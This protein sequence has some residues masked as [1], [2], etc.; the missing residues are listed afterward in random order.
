[1]VINIQ[2]RVTDFKTTSSLILAQEKKKDNYF[3][4]FTSRNNKN[5]LDFNNNLSSFSIK[6]YICSKK[7]TH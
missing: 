3:G 1:M 4:G 7:D 5:Y 2:I 6:N